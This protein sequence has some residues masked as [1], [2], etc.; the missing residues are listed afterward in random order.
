MHDDLRRVLEGPSTYRNEIL[1]ALMA[2]PNSNELA[3]LIAMAD[4]DETVRLRLLRA[5]RDLSV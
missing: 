3:T 5:I 2:R 1:K 4:T